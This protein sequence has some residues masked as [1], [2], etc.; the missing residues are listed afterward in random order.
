[1]WYFRM[2]TSALFTPHMPFVTLSRPN[3][4]FSN[5]N[6]VL[7]K[8][9]HSVMLMCCVLCAPMWTLF[10]HKPPEE[11]NNKKEKDFKDF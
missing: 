4:A 9:R 7:L 5:V 1:M 2:Q 8:L 6:S 10:C 3:L 11:E